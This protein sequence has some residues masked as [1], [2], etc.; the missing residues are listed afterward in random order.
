[1]IP[2]IGGATLSVALHIGLVGL[3]L[4]S[5]AAD[6][7]REP[8]FVD[9]VG[10][11]HPPG[12]AADG[13]PT[14][15]PAAR[16]TAPIPAARPAPPAP[17]PAPVVPAPSAPPVSASAPSPAPTAAPPPVPPP[18]PSPP[19]AALEPT[20]SPAPVPVPPPAVAAAPPAS[21]EPR[22]TGE[23]V[24]SQAPTTHGGGP[25][26]GDIERGP[27]G[28]PG[29]PLALALP[30]TGG[31]GSVPAEYG[32]YLRRFRQRVLE[33]LSYPLAARRQGLSGTVELHVWLEAS[34]RIRDVQIVR[35]S[36][37]GLLDEAA[38]ET[39]RGL[40]PVPFPDSLP[41]RP[42]VIRLPLVFELR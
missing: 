31:G 15:A 24:G 19:I 23:P 10:S 27:V 29:A 34:G 12:P 13:R 39:V 35:S 20:P 21:G 8:L 28:P 16:S 4:A 6:S 25:D 14:P 22:G 2:G 37:H 26:H 38:V 3:L 9:M 5:S 17:A 1:M 36:A 41:R 18:A 33:S 40:A 32:P 42:L 7:T 30:G 11:D